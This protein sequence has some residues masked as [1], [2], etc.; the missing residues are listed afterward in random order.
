MRLFE[1]TLDTIL[2]NGPETGTFN[3]SLTPSQA[4]AAQP[5]QPDPAGLTKT[6][7]AP[8]QASTDGNQKWGTVEQWQQ[9]EQMRE[10]A[11]AEKMNG[12]TIDQKIELALKQA[13]QAEKIAYRSSAGIS[14]LDAKLDRVF[15]NLSGMIQR[16]G[17]GKPAVEPD[18]PGSSIFDDDD[19]P[20]S[21]FSSQKPR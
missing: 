2:E 6:Y 5:Q 20:E 16:V 18:P 10:Q 3:N 21:I 1:Q 14:A 9:V 11:K 12:L 17:S 7:V 4:A 15:Q 19:D 8:P 13:E